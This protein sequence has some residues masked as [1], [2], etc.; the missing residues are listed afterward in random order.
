MSS[1]GNIVV[2][3]VRHSTKIC[4]WNTGS[5]ESSIVVLVYE[6]SS[7][8][9]SWNRVRPQNLSPAYHCNMPESLMRES[10]SG[11]TNP[12]TLLDSMQIVEIC[13]AAFRPLSTWSDDADDCTLVSVAAVEAVIE[14]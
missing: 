11:V 2:P 14:D 6:L 9:I 5:S 10:V 4:G 13:L 8:Q 1:G 12:D 3:N 7:G